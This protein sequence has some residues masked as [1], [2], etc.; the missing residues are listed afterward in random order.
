MLLAIDVDWCFYPEKGAG[1]HL[2]VQFVL[3]IFHLCATV[4]IACCGLK[5]S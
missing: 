1:I 4:I 2:Y 5:F 3:D